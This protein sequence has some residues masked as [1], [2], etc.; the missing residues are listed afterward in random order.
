MNKIE[1]LFG[2]VLIL[3]YAIER[4]NTPKA[5]RAS[6]TAGRYFS[7]AII[8][9]LIYLATFYVI[10]TNEQL[11][12]LVLMLV[13]ATGSESTQLHELESTAVVAA[14]LLSL[15]VPKLPVISDIDTKLRAFLHRLAAIPYEAIRLSQE[16][17]HSRYEVPPA[18]NESV[19]AELEEQ[20]IEMDSGDPVIRK[21]IEL[22]SLMVQLREWTASRQFAFFFLERSNE[23]ERMHERYVRLTK[24]AVNAIALTKQAKSQPEVGALQ[25]ASTAFRRDLRSEQRALLSEICDFISHGVLR[26]CF[27]NDSRHKTL[28]LMGFID[29]RK[30]SGLGFSLNQAVVLFGLLLVLVLSNFILFNFQF[31]APTPDVQGELLRVVMI[32]SIYSASVICAV[33]PKHRWRLLQLEENGSYPF[34]GYMISGGM[35][36][37]ASAAISLFFNSMIYISSGQSLPDAFASAA[38]RFAYSHPW[39]T[40]AFVAAASTAFLIDWRR[41]AWLSGFP[42]RVVEGLSQAVLLMATGA[43]VYWWILGLSNDPAFTGRVPELT[44]VIPTM[45]VVGF[46]IGF[47]V[48]T[49]YRASLGRAVIGADAGPADRSVA[50]IMPLYEAKSGPGATARVGGGSRGPVR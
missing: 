16:I 41:P 42:G 38:S 18:V 12:G 9:P 49:W 29:V 6:T 3:V 10:A 39:L 27:R 48:P 35:A 21:W 8:Y 45:A 15:L 5:I 11:L 46:T 7:A 1:L 32:V 26:T 20:G 2:A 47:L 43:L 31:R 37:L 13:D 44:T 34:F 4:F 25:Q 17:Q 30:D 24:I 23:F 50:A 33:V 40:V 14:L 19:L 36:I 22:V 28:H